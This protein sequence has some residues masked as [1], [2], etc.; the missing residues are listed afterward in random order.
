[1]RKFE[2]EKKGRN[3]IFQMA[4]CADTFLLVFEKNTKKFFINFGVV[5]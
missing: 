3:F 4:A 2:F 5:K 1:M